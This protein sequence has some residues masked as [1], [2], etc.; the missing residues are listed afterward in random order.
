MGLATELFRRTPNLERREIKYNWTLVQLMLSRTRSS[1]PNQAWPLRPIQN[2]VFTT[3]FSLLV[4]FYLKLGHS[5]RDSGLKLRSCG[6]LSYS[7]NMTQPG[8]ELTRMTSCMNQLFGSQLWSWPQLTVSELSV[9]FI[10]RIYPRRTALVDGDI[11][12]SV[13]E[14]YTCCTQCITG[15]K[16]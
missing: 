3:S 5:C 7:I 9:S 12:W 11:L 4:L 14:T 2:L 1:T 6:S 16:S 13:V 10:L 8:T 15:K